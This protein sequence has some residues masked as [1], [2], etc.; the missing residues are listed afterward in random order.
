MSEEKYGSNLMVEACAHPRQ[1]TFILSF[2]VTSNVDIL[3]LL[4]LMYNENFLVATSV[5]FQVLV[6]HTST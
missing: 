1:T 6:S 5:F 4:L 3:R 2:R